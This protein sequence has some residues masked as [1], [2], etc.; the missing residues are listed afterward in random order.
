M[1][2]GNL[3]SHNQGSLNTLSGP[4]N[5]VNHNMLSAS[6]LNDKV[7]NLYVPNGA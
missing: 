7:L 5:M 4:Y 6:D 2:M 1:T 3:G